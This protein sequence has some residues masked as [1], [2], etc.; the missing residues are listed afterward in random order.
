M[1]AELRVLIIYFST[2]LL[3]FSC[4][5][6]DSSRMILTDLHGHPQSFSI[7][8]ELGVQVVV[9]MSPECP[10]CVYYSGPLNSLYDEFAGDSVRFAAVFPDTVYNRKQIDD[11]VVEYGFKWPVLLDEHN[12]LRDRLGATI[13]PQ[14]FV[15]G[16]D[17]Q[18][19]YSGAIDD[20]AVTVRKHRQVVHHHYLRDALVASINQKPVDPA[21]TDPIGCFIQ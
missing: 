4:V 18:V 8:A 2:I 12:L 11:F 1:R 10:L 13:T 7:R 14:V 20:W 6:A 21:R 15:L 17:G 16:T 9:F 5:N 19:L 3:M